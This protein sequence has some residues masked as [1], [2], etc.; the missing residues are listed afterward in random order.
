MTKRATGLL[1][2]A[3]L[4]LSSCSPR[5]IEHSVVRTDTTY[6]EKHLLD[7]I[8][9]RDSIYVRETA[10]TV[11]H[12]VERWRDRYVYM[13]DTVSRVVRDTTVVHQV[14]VVEVDSPLKWWK[15]GL[16]GAGAALAVAGLVML[17]IGIVKLFKL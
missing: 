13:T 5:I 16:M 6:I 14:E 10:D 9:F 8:Y 3:A 11:Y 1:L 2:T 12:Y 15:K 7:S 17:V 4:I